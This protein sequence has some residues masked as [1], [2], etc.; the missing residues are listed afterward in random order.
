M[1]GAAGVGGHAQARDSS[2]RAAPSAQNDR[3]DA[4]WVMQDVAP[5]KANINAH[6]RFPSLRSGGQKNEKRPLLQPFFRFYCALAGAA[7]ILREM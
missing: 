2:L 1:G 3:G 7:P 4:G 5:F 6:A